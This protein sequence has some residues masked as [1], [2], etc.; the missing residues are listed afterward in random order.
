MYDSKIVSELF[1]EI[2]LD[3]W[4]TVLGNNLDY[5]FSNICLE[6]NPVFNG[7]SSVLDVGCGWGGTMRDLKHLYGIKS[8]G[9]TCSKQQK[10]YIGEDAILADANSLVLKDKFDLVIFIQSFCHME[11]NALYLRA[12]NTNKIFISDFMT[13]GNETVIAKE[14]LMI[15]RTE[16]HFDKL[17]EDIGF[18][19]TEKVIRPQE[20]FVPNA[21]IWLDNIRSNKIT[22]GWHIIQLEKLCANI[23]SGLFKNKKISIVDYYA[24]R[25]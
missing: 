18:K 13:H 3:T 22:N 1:D 8:K 23:V 15:M 19:I 24:E 16:K 7:V 2:T 6:T 5:H 25:K 4:Q 12:Q 20:D 9:I 17:F 21:Q 11:D 14:E 10:E